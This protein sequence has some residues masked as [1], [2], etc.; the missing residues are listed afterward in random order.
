MPTMASYPMAMA[1]PTKMGMKGRVS[2]KRPMVEE[3][4]PTRI[5]NRGMIITFEFPV[6]RLSMLPTRPLKAPLLMMS[7]MAA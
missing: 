3:V 7:P 5:M 6:R 2:S 4:E 1:M